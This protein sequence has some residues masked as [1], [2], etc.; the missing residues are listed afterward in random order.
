MKKKSFMKNTSKNN[1]VQYEE[2]Q[3]FKE[4]IDWDAVW[5]MHPWDKEKVLRGL[6]KPPMKKVIKDA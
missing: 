5:G 6:R 3:D 2:A 1:P 4:I